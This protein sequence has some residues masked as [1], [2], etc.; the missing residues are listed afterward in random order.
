MASRSDIPRDRARQALQNLLSG[1]PSQ[2]LM[3]ARD[4]VLTELQNVRTASG[5]REVRAIY[6]TL[7]A[8]YREAL[9]NESVRSFTR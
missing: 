9:R 5:E 7:D 6:D 1:I 2:H 3:T 4:H 8:A